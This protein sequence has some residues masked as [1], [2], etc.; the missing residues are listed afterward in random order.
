MSL[1]DLLDDVPEEVSEQHGEGYFA[2]R[3]RTERAR[4]AIA[5]KR[6]RDK[7][8][9]IPDRQC[10]DPAEKFRRTRFSKKPKAEE[11]IRYDPKIDGQL[12]IH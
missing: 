10:L 9:A 2:R 1:A 5:V 12:D 4:I 11:A 6:E 3:R 7:T 8:P